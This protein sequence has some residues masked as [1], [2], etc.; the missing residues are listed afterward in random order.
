[1]QINHIGIVV[2]NIVESSKYYIDCFQYTIN[3]EVFKDPIQKVKIQFLQSQNQEN[4]IE[5]IEPM[6]G[7]SPVL[8]SLKKGGG[9]NHLCYEVKDIEQSIALFRKKGCRIIS[10][11][12]PA[13]AFGNRK[14]AFLY[15]RQ[16]ELI[17]FVELKNV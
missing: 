4:T 16:R 5:L 15:T 10:G 11:P 13:I 14:V 3:S 12:V 9:L 2:K 17:E 8:N 7:D 1:M 6:G